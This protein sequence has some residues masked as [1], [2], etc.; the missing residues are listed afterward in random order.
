[1]NLQKENLELWN[2][3]LENLD[4]LGRIRWAWGKFGD[5]LLSSTSFGLQSAVMIHLV[6]EVSREIPIVFVDTGYLFPGT[7]QYAIQL[8]K[9]LNF[10][11]KVYSARKSPAFQEAEYGKLWEQGSDEMNHYNLINKKE[12]MDRAIKELK[13]TAWV[14]GL[15]REQSA[16]RESL[17]YLELQNGVYKLYPILDWTD[18]KPINIYPKT[19]CLTT[20]WKVLGMILLGIGTAL[21]NCRKL[22]LRKKPGTVVMEENVDCTWKCRMDWILMFD[23]KTHDFPEDKARMNELIKRT[24]HLW[25]FLE[26]DAKKDKIIQL[27]K[28]MSLPSF[29]DDQSTARKV[30]AENNRL[31]QSVSKVED[32]R[33]QVEDLEALCELCEE[34]QE[35]EEMAK[36]FVLILE[37]LIPKIDDLEVASFLSEPFDAR[38]ALLSIHAGAGGTE[39][40]DWAD[41]LMRMYMR[42]AERRGFSVELQDLQAGEEAGIS[43]CS[44]RIEGLNAYGYAKAERGVHRLVRISPFDS[45]KRR[46]TSF[47]S[48]DVIAEVED[49]DI[50]MDIP[51]DDLRVDTYRS[52]GKGGQHV[53]KTDS[54]VRLTHLPTN[55]V[56]QCQNQRSQLKNKQTAMKVLKSRLYEKQQDEKRAE[57]EKFYGEKGEMGWGNQ[58]RSYVF[59]PYQMVKDLRTGVETSGVQAVMD[60]E[61]DP[62]VNGWLRAGCPRQR[63]KDI[64]I[65][66]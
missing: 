50:D 52:S 24:N 36:E 26:C 44:I 9:H 58:I 46:H 27:E 56:V 42:W 18:R 21:K 17:P 3:E 22:I 43:R 39:S 23:P 47:C 64:Q 53:N 37:K 15:R 4:S 33:S 16:R 62:F 32:F 5:G 2:E 28:E 20:H 61:L 19:I 59:Q 65:D 35:D 66:D 8:Q 6:C 7:Y 1:M 60:G 57:M 45:N 55:I 10:E 25:K 54:A 41:M 49:D 11:A 30:S 14:A 63:N 12:P 34:D 40:C 13:A 51:E 38:P 29:W 48:V 31:K